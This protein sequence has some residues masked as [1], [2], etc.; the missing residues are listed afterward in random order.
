[1]SCRT[2]I[3]AGA[4]GVMVNPGATRKGFGTEA[5]KI[6]T[7]YGLR[8][9]GLVEMEPEV[10]KKGD[11]FGDDLLWRINIKSWSPLLG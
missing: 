2:A 7:D 11:H 1:M 5:L 4:A 10:E 9:L 3:G 8:K 6:V